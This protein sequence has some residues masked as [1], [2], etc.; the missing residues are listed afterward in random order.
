MRVHARQGLRLRA[1]AAVLVALAFAPPAYSA[2]ARSVATRTWTEVR[3]PHVQVLTDGG[4]EV[5]ERV[6][7]RMEDLRAALA[8]ATPALVA[9]VAPV[10]VIVFRDEALARAYAPTWR[11]L[12]DDVA[13]FFHAGPDRRR[14]LFVDDRGRTP[15]VA[16]HEYTHALLDAALPDAPLWLNEG[17]AEYFST[18][19]V[20]GE[21]ARA[22][23]P[24]PAHVEWL[25]GHDLMPLA[26]LFA[27]GQGSSAYHEGDRRGT[28]YAQSWALT[29]LLL[30]G[31]GEDPGRLERVLVATR[32]GE[33]FAAAFRAEFG[34]EGALRDR[35]FALLERQRFLERDWAQSTTSRAALAPRVRNRIPPA[36]V[37]ASLGIGFLARPTPQREEAEAHLG[38]ALALDA[39]HADA[40]AGMGWLQLQRGR[41]AEA[42][43]WFERALAPEVVS[44][45]AVR[46]LASQ[47]LLDVSRRQAQDERRD[48]GLFARGALE[49]ARAAEPADPELVAL[50]ARSWVVWHD[51][52]AEPGYTL[53]TRAAEALPGRADVQL[54]LLAL[55]ALTGR[56]EEATQIAERRFAS[57]VAPELRRAARTALLA[58]DVRAANL[59]VAAGDAAGAEA[60][61]RAARSRVADDP[62]L[63]R[64]ADR[65]LA[66]FTQA[67]ERQD[68]TL[69][70]NRAIAEYNAGVTSANARRF[71]E[72]AAA[73]RRAAEASGRDAFRADARRM[74]RRMDMRVQGE[75]AMELARQGDTAGAR[76]LLE[77]MDRSVL[78]AEDRRWLDTN[79]AR[80]RR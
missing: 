26:E 39:R 42:R 19:R 60:R 31:P 23:G 58:G 70:E 59:R 17:L 38:E 36:D 7:S 80:L 76:A 47:L 43:T 56:D 48:I 30:S 44:A 8:A 21:S 75:R 72:A 12:K 25:A 50:L 55:A 35:L 15:S 46:L 16:Q 65:Y 54:D 61:L 45:S 77:A 64:E 9:D 68:E 53:A 41:R 66:Q 62:E 4:R 49:R 14:V 11:G 2:G 10:Q 51:D 34:D 78:D 13:G 40:C 69:H 32:D 3:T 5:G 6:A 37:L 18:F 28:F 27:M 57:G 71:A 22:G 20:E 1:G 52:D 67:R 33:P 24:V 73:F 79:L 74:A 63:V 29:H